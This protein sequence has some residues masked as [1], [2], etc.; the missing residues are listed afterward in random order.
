MRTRLV[1]ALVTILLFVS[2][3]STSTVAE[4]QETLT[5]VASQ[6]TSN[7]GVGDNLKFTWTV[8]GTRRRVKLK[9]T[10]KN[11]AVARLNGGNVQTVTTSGGEPNTVSVTARGRQA[12]VFEVKAE[13]ADQRD[14]RLAGTTAGRGESPESGTAGTG[15]PSIGRP[16]I[17]TPPIGT[18]PVTTPTTTEPEPPNR[19]VH[20]R[21]VKA[22]APA[23]NRIASRTAEAARRLRVRQGRVRVDDVLEI[24]DDAEKELRE[25]L[26]QRE[27]EPF[28]DAA[29][30][31]LDRIRRD[32]QAAASEARFASGIVLVASAPRKEIEESAARSLL[33]EVVDFFRGAAN[34][35]P[36]TRICVKTDP[37]NGATVKLSPRSFQ[38]WQGVKSTSPITLYV[39]LYRYEVTRRGYLASKGEVNLLTN[40]DRLL[41]LPLRRHEDDSEAPQ[42]EHLAGPCQ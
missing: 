12:G 2:C 42:Y 9:I 41:I 20:E 6:E 3:G 30:E 34:T 29:A 26:P 16:P 10:N 19:K 13:F 38:K 18:P 36:L 17:G 37:V 28:R 24:V 14:R 31:F 25:A 4:K 23:L 32:V 5:I 15:R 21:I 35:S 11:P 22:F 40:P 27:L 1:I 8:R 7:I 33:S 39:G